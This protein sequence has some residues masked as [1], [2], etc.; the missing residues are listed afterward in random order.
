MITTPLLLEFENLRHK[1]GWF[2]ILGIIMV[3]LGTAALVIAPA[4]TIG[5][6]MVLGWLIVASGVMEAFH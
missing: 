5:T 6:V 4:A 1:W 2:L 3:L